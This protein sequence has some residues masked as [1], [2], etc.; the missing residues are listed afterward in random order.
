MQPNTKTILAVELVVAYSFLRAFV[1][2]GDI[3][4]Y[5]TS[6]QM[7]IRIFIMRVNNITSDTLDP[8]AS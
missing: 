7:F 6:M 3:L 5:L 8:V 1:N 4:T 2:S